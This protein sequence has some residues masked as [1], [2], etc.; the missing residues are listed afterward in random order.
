MK[1]Y[2]AGGSLE[3]KHHVDHLAGK[4]VVFFNKG[5]VSFYEKVGEERCKK[6]FVIQILFPNNGE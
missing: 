6:H 3:V 4:E 1:N 2:G 5:I